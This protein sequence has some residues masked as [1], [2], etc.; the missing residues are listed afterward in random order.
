MSIPTFS[1]LLRIFEVIAR[2][3][4]IFQSVLVATFSALVAE[5]FQTFENEVRFI[6]GSRIS[7]AKFL[8]FANR[9]LPIVNIGLAVYTFVLTKGAS[10]R[11]CLNEY[12]ALSVIAFVEFEIAYAVLCIRA[13]AAWGFARPVLVVL[14][15]SSITSVSA[16]VY[17][18]WRFL[19]G[20]SAL[21]P[22]VVTNVCI[23]EALNQDIRINVIILACVDSLPLALLLAKSWKTFRSAPNDSSLLLIMAKDGIG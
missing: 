2:F 6:W 20:T 15:T 14:L 23:T 9:Y 10:A 18:L 13:Y 12:L 11:T 3:N 17:I 19:S 7:L 22:G 5:F 4:Q 21:D 8:Y 16:Q 1:Q